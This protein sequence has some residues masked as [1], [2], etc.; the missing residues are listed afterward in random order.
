V[1]DLGSGRGSFPMGDWPFTV[2]RLDEDLDTCL[3][4]RDRAPREFVLPASGGALPLQAASIDVVVCNHVLEHVSELDPVLHEIRRV[5]KPGGRLFVTVPNGYGICDGVYRWVFEGGGHV[6]RH[7]RAELAALVERE[8][9]LHLRQWQ[10]LYSSFVYL[11][12][13][14]PLLEA[15]PQDFGRRLRRLGRLPSATLRVAQAALYVGTRLWERLFGG[16]AAGYGWAF[17]FEPEP[18]PL[19]QEPPYI[20]VC[21]AC[22]T[23]EPRGEVQRLG[24]FRW[25]CPVCACSNFLPDWP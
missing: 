14:L 21:R 5:L 2:I 18:G 12:R 7:R 25:R 19:H 23:G 22:G 1:L 9:G 13:V 6:Q 10:R 3:E 16:E 15:R 17:W 20:N 8:T 4:P 24:R 11:W